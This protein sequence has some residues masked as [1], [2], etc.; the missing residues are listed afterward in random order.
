[1]ASLLPP[2]YRK[3]FFLVD[4]RGSSSSSGIRTFTLKPKGASF[5]LVQS[6]ELVWSVLA[7]DADFGPDGALYFS[8]WVEGWAKPNKG[9]IYRVLDRSRI[10]DPI[11]REV[12]TLLTE[13]L[14]TQPEQALARLLGHPDMRIRQEA[15]FEL[16]ARGE[17][18]WRTL[19]E[20]AGSKGGTLPRIHAIW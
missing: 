10:G 20:V 8:D 13:G 7:T 2:E 19:G 16:A 3:H 14:G 17:A 6:R 4:F 9:R 18:G 5:E 12:K 15:Q 11:V 1:G